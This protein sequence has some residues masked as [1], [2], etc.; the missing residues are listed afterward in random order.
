VAIKSSKISVNIDA[1][2]A[3]LLAVLAKQEKMSVEAFVKQLILEELDRREDEAL[4][5]I[6]H[7]REAHGEKRISHE[8]AWK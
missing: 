2:A 4:C 6:A 7:E 8:E 3:G 5:A 1:A